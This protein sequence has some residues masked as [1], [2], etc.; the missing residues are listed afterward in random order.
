MLNYIEAG[1]R[2]EVIA[3]NAAYGSLSAPLSRISPFLHPVTHSTEAEIELENPD[4]V[5]IPG[6]FVTVDIYYG[7]SESA[8]LIPLS[9]LYENPISGVTGVYTTDDSLN[10]ETVATIEDDPDIL[11]TNPVVFKFTPID[12]IAR[13][14]MHAGISGIDPGRWVI[15]IGQDLLGGEPTGEARVRKVDWN[16]VEHLQNLQRQDLMLEIINKRQETIEDSTT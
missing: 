13:G 3:G 1:Q 7:E 2:T 9:A 12:I 5:L 14:R 16:W 11:L 15:T 10:Q 6:M 4:G 8:T